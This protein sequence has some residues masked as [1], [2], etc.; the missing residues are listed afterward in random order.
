MTR[1]LRR[2]A[3]RIV[4]GAVLVV[5]V[6]GA[7]SVYATYQREQRI[8]KE[9]EAYG[10]KVDW[11]Y[12]GPD[13]IPQSI[14]DRTMLFGRVTVIYLD[15]SLVTDAGLEHLKE[16]TKLKALY[17]SNTQVTDAGLE[18]LKELTNLEWL[19]LS[20]THV[21]DA[22]LQH[23]KGLTNLTEFD[24]CNPKLT[25]ANGHVS[26]TQVTDAG[27]EHLKGL[28]TLA[29]LAV[30]NT[31]D[32]GLEHLKGLTNLESLYISNRQ[33]TEEGRAMLRKALPNCD[34]QP[35]P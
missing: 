27:L 26:N 20:N 29:K 30:S 19:D 15:N 22:G 12:F 6:Y 10:E 21:T 5:A 13:W 9:I 34:I 2:H 28:T 18:H 3:V 31:T 35:D 8:A 4:I 11:Q 33:T 25:D 17:L 16:L 1:F 24:L 23:L 14:R 7:I 32:A